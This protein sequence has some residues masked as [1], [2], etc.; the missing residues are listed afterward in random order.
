MKKAKI[1]IL[2]GL[3]LVFLLLYFSGLGKYLT[4]DSLKQQREMVLTYYQA[5]P[6]QVTAAYM[7][8]YIVLTAVSFP[9]ATVLTLAG[10]A[11]FGVLTGTLLIVFSA[12]VGAVCAFLAAR[13]IFR[14][15]F[16][17][18]VGD[19][20]ARFNR[21]IRENGFYYLLFLRLIPIFPFFLI[22]A[23]MGLTQLR[24]H[25]FLLATFIGIIPGT[26]VYA[27]AGRQLSEISSLG[28]I[29]SADVLIAFGL[30]A[31]VSLLPPLYQA[32]RKRVAG[33]PKDG[34]LSQ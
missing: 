4:L 32:V 26:A 9:G 16:E 18:R 15:T 19:R 6:F 31:A 1:A 25:T 20:V 13:F 23:G 34:R 29:L 2:A 11:I 28:D 24:L 10:G 30:L 27:N 14:E 8:I 21:G 33:K 22:N 12:T 7:L 17:Q 3:V 5:H